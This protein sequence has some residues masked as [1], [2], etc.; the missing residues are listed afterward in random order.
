[1]NLSNA[2][3]LRRAREQLKV[4]KVE[5]ARKLKVSVKTI[6]RIE[7]GEGPLTE[8]K[9]NEV[10]S[11]L[12]ISVEEFLK[13][14]KGRGPFRKKRERLV[15]ENALRRSY[16]K[17][18]TKEVQVL[19]TLRKM[20]GISQDQASSLCG[21]SRPSIGHIENGRIE[22]DQDRITHVVS[23]YGVQLSE[24]HRLMGEEVLR[25]EVLDKCL[26]KMMGLSEEKLKLI[27]ALL[28]TF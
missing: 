24:F 14:K 18:I 20:K 6:D 1:M 21:Y 3:T 2:K 15:T 27:Q 5:L 11:S 19:K 7:N 22:L 17:V 8:S 26:S 23:C 10:L 9:I 28:Q 4:T 13:V 25:D 12:G 16:K